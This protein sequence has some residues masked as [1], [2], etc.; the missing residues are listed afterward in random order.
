LILVRLR[1]TQAVYGFM[2][3]A[4]AANL[5]R[6]TADSI[7]DLTSQAPALLPSLGSVSFHVDHDLPT[8]L[9]AFSQS[10]HL[11][12]DPWVTRARVMFALSRHRFDEAIQLLNAALIQD[13]FLPGSMAG[14]PGL[15]TW[16]ASR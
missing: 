10:A 4:V 8:A 7:P 3:P 15:C 2:S 16:P 14:S 9:W 6:R 5:V 12:H 13:P 11:P 1:I